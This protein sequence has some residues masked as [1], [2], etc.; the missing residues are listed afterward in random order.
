MNILDRKK[1]TSIFI[2]L[3]LV[4][5]LIAQD[6]GTVDKKGNMFVSARVIFVDDYSNE[7]SLGV[8][9]NISKNHLILLN[10]LDTN[11]ICYENIVA[12]YSLVLDLKVNNVYNF[13]ISK[14]ET[15]THYIEEKRN[16]TLY[17][18]NIKA[19]PNRMP[20]KHRVLSH[21]SDYK[22]SFYIDAVSEIELSY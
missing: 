5:N 13:S 16:D 10:I 8:K 18:T 11:K 3:F 7:I 4:T 9:E 21:P 20:C 2:G 17:I 22:Y 14:K 6:I 15:Q 1:I 19:M 12:Y